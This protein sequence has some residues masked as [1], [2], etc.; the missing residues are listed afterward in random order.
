M[1]RTFSYSKRY[2]AGLVVAAS[3][4]LWPFLFALGVHVYQGA[5]LDIPWLI[6]TFAAPFF[7]IPLIWWGVVGWH[8]FQSRT[9]V[10]SAQGIEVRRG[11]RVWQSIPWSSHPTI[12]K[13]LSASD[14][15][16]WETIEVADGDRKISIE[17]KIRDY[18][19]LKELLNAL[20]EEKDLPITVVDETRWKRR[21]ESGPIARL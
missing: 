1:P 6:A 3:V 12:T 10:V 5:A 20:G 14:G 7:P 15:D 19:D 8:A 13:T 2:F 18:D 4:P 17:G 9:I 11:S 16:V 21:V